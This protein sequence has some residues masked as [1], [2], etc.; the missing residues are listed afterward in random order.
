MMKMPVVFV[1]HGSPMNAIEDN[2][3]QEAG[4]KCRKDPEAEGHIV[5]FAHWYTNGTRIMNEENPRTVYDMYGFRRN[6]MKSHTTHPIPEIAKMAKTLISK[7]TKYDNSWGI[8]HGTWSVLVHMYRTEIFPF[9]KSASMLMP[10]GGSLQNRQG[11]KRFKRA[12]GSVVR[13]GEHCPQLK[14]GGLA[15]RKQ[16]IRLGVRVRRIYLQEHHEWK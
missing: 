11:A 1:G 10:S 6:C 2:N 4:E 5:R 8:D 3:I 16:G 7:E 14:T 15:P 12:R 13:Y 9:F